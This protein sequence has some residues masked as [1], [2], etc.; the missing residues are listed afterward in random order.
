M[1]L[2]YLLLQQIWTF[3]SSRYHLYLK[4]WRA[5]Q[6]YVVR[7]KVK[8]AKASVALMQANFVILKRFFRNWQGYCVECR[9]KHARQMEAM[10]FRQ[11]KI[12]QKFFVKWLGSL[13]I[14][15]IHNQKDATAQRH[16]KETLE[17]KMFSEW[18]RFVKLQRGEKL[19]ISQ[20][21]R[22]YEKTLTSKCLFQGF[23]P[24]ILHRRDRLEAKALASQFYMDRLQSKTFHHWQ[25]R[26]AVHQ[27]IL[28]KQEEIE[29]LGRRSK[30]KRIIKHWKYYVKLC[31][32]DRQ[33]MRIAVLHHQGSLMQLAFSSLKLTVVVR[34]LKLLQNEQA[35]D[36]HH[37]QTLLRAWTRWMRRIEDREESEMFED[38]EKA[39]DHFRQLTLKKTM[40][41]WRQYLNWRQHR[42]NAYRTAEAHHQQDLC[43]RALCALAANVQGQE[44]KRQITD[45][46]NQFYRYHVMNAA[47]NQWKE[48]YH[49]S[50][51]RRSM[52][53]MAILHHQKN[54][55]TAVFI[56]WK[57]R[58][59]DVL[60]GRDNMM[61]ANRYF[62]RHLCR[63]H[64]DQWREFVQDTKERKVKEGTSIIHYNVCILR[65]VWTAWTKDTQRRRKKATSIRKAEQYNDFKILRLAMTH[66][67]IYQTEVTTKLAISESKYNRIMKERMRL[68]FDLWRSNVQEHKKAR[69][70]QDVAES[71]HGNLIVSQSFNA[72]HR[73]T[74]T[75]AIK[76]QKQKD[77]LS[78]ALEQLD[79]EKLRRYFCDW[80]LLRR[81]HAAYRAA[82][83]KATDHFHGKTMKDVFKRWKEFKQIQTRKLI[84]HQ[85][86]TW[87]DVTRLEAKFFLLWKKHY[88]RS[89]RERSE[90]NV[91]LWHWSL[92]L[93]G[94]ALVAWKSYV[95][96]RREKKERIEGAMVLRHQ[97]LLET[98]LRKWIMTADGLSQ[99]RVKNLSEKQGKAASKSFLVVRRCALHWR[100]KTLMR[101]TR[102][103]GGIKE[104]SSDFW[105]G[106]SFQISN[107]T[108]RPR[109]KWPDFLRSSLQDA[110]LWESVE[111]SLSRP[112]R[113]ELVDENETQSEQTREPYY[114]VSDTLDVTLPEGSVQSCDKRRTSH[115]K[116]SKSQNKSSGSCDDTLGDI[117][118]HDVSF[119]SEL[120]I[121]GDKK[122][123]TATEE[124]G[125]EEEEG[126]SVSLR[127]PI[128]RLQ[129]RRLLPPSAF[130][131]MQSAFMNMQS[132]EVEQVAGT[133]KR[134]VSWSSKLQE[135]TSEASETQ[136]EDEEFVKD[137]GKREKHFTDHRHHL[138]MRQDDSD[139]EEDED[140]DYGDDSGG[141]HVESSNTATVTT[142][143]KILALKNLLLEY[144]RLKNQVILLEDQRKALMF[145]LEEPGD[146]TREE[147]KLVQE[148]IQQHSQSLTA[149]KEQISSLMVEIGIQNS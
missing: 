98:G 130:M 50:L 26:L 134:K 66:W 48:T 106:A 57:N 42:K 25:R 17:R 36:F 9:L 105:L 44:V 95:K 80:R 53:R 30:L 137:V 115:E 102:E 88:V 97:R 113:R 149:I 145:L 99:T 70:C 89:L 110:G 51:E 39:R 129:T 136:T 13:E 55:M 68:A 118:G 147:Y 117:Q 108:S 10:E 29:A 3:Q 120:N 62:K 114:E 72:W 119:S 125:E 8:K 126:N 71:H 148:D 111:E 122:L 35:S 91:A 141:D 139:D 2:L 61:A 76:V 135:V 133:I 7:Q 123:R 31:Y 81:D 58:T 38:T 28:Q 27:N 65:K 75:R 14:S 109:P 49:L 54:S 79:R 15:R 92:V 63:Q 86:S 40:V 20:A 124:K 107:S 47:F 56:L 84:L 24:Y 1:M 112:T 94:K 144:Q 33:N 85:Q 131:N 52:E 77:Q 5:W 100:Q 46:S 93:Q 67:K 74:L 11:R 32:N 128:I 59:D 104:P 87:L 140:D 16:W 142:K 22:F 37:K 43:Y 23:L 4:I 78:E 121:L 45:Q 64:F 12:L 6:V 18:K 132:E 41:S 103:G 60:C 146:G 138:E 101:R 90:T 83:K 69:Q 21:E 34:R 127:E 116:S 73:Y 96:T 143:D 82:Y 19:K